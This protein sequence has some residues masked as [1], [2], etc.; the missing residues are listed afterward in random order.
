MS[1]NNSYFWADVEEA[2][3]GQNRVASVLNSLGKESVAAALQEP[4]QKEV[5]RRV[6][7]GLLAVGSTDILGWANRSEVFHFLGSKEACLQAALDVFFPL[8]RT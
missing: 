1:L 6:Q 8:K 3:D 2:V 7:E 5:C 4:F